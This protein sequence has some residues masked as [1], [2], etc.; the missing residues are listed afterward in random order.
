MA[1]Q[2]H[3][4][5]AISE[6]TVSCPCRSLFSWTAGRGGSSRFEDVLKL[7]GAW[8]T[9][10]GMIL[11]LIGFIDSRHV[12]LTGFIFFHKPCQ[13]DIFGSLEIRAWHVQYADI[14]DDILDLNTSVLAIRPRCIK[15]LPQVFG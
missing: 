12:S 8:I 9:G 1:W 3:S 11:S 14:A 6:V 13:P 5:E 15:E 10:R 4:G 2:L 7:K